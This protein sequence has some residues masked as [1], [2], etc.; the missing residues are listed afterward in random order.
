MAAFILRKKPEQSGKH[1]ALEIFR[2][3]SDLEARVTV[4]ILD[5]KDGKY[6]LYSLACFIYINT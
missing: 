5:K 1:L 3:T 6:A 2:I 4:N